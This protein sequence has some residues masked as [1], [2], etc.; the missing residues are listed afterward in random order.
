MSDQAPDC[1]QADFYEQRYR[2]FADRAATL[3]FEVDRILIPLFTGIIAGLLALLT[4]RTV[5]FWS[6]VCFVLADVASI[7]GL[8]SCLMHVTF[9]AKALGSLAAM[10]GGDAN[11]PNLISK[12]EPSVHAF[13]KNRLYAQMCY[14][15]QLL[16][17]FWSVLLGG[18]GVIAVVW[19]SLG[20]IGLFVALLF[21]TCMTA[22]TVR[23]L[24]LV[25]RLAR[26]ALDS[27]KGGEVGT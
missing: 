6:A 3:A 13:K 26:N 7:V 24:V 11:V 18:I 12:E 16:C 14:A 5:G 25:H 1:D 22:V 27:E 17:L 2:F 8:A 9:S 10:F 21:A 23:P 4:S 15:N 20:W 19:D